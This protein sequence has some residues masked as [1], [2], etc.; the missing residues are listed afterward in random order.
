MTL[1]SIYSYGKTVSLMYSLL[2]VFIWLPC[3]MVRKLGNQDRERQ[4]S[5]D[6]E[7]NHLYLALS[8]DRSEQLLIQHSTVWPKQN[9]CADHSWFPSL[10]YNNWPMSVAWMLWEEIHLEFNVSSSSWGFIFFSI[11]M[12]IGANTREANV[13]IKKWWILKL[14]VQCFQT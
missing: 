12:H 1:N 11:M 14:M 2:S 9:L 5:V 7:G 13:R 3:G 6:N 10:T 8:S 4:T